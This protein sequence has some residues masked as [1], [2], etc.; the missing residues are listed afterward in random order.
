MA[1]NFLWYLSLTLTLFSALSAVLA[2]GW[3]ANYS[4][5]AQGE[6]SSN[7]CE[8]HLR[9]LRARQWRLGGVV[10]GIPLLIQTALSLFFLGL[11]IFALSDNAGIGFTILALTIF[12]T[13]IYLVGT[14]LPWFSPACP[15][16]TTVSNFI[17]EVT[18]Q[19]QYDSHPSR[20]SPSRKPVNFS[21]LRTIMV[22]SW[23][24]L[25]HKP[26]QS[27]AE[28][29]ILAW[30]L[31]NSKKEDVIKEA[32]KAIAG[33]R[34]TLVLQEALHDPSAINNLCQ[35][36]GQCFKYSPGHAIDI[37]DGEAYLHAMLRLVQPVA[38]R[39]KSE[40]LEELLQSGQALHRW[41]NFH[42]CL[43]AL[44]FSL[45]IHILIHFDRDDFESQERTK[46]KLRK[47]AEIASRPH[48]RRVMVTAAVIGF[49]YGK[50]NLQQM[51]DT[52]LLKQSKIGEM[53][54]MVMNT[55]F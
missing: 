23:R 5:A 6:H 53:H 7:A 4:P 43:Q 33:A 8:R 19:A 10:A 18:Q 9:A 48:V 28:A 47:M 42:P 29:E 36:F 39:G 37:Q 27:K 14:I 50:S 41:D 11:V 13:I 45:R 2:K 34:P 52:V 54:D 49:I 26:Q 25:H 24:K 21:M 12:S 55:R 3:L 46:E 32:V 40:L 15:F 35:R 20:G 51:C 31:T 30:V 17:P 16:Q 38:K 1:V 22:E 44:A